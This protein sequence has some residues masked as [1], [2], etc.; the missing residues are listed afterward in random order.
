MIS[1]KHSFLT[2]YERKNSDAF[3]ENGFLISNSNE[4]Y[5][6]LIIKRLRPS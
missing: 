3:N 6:D 4:E 2:E 5:S 1:E